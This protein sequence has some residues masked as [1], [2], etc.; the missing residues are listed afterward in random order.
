[1][2]CASHLSNVV[3]VELQSGRGGEEAVVAAQVEH[4]RVLRGEDKAT[5]RQQPFLGLLY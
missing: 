2:Q 5:H 1:M 4:F 3:L